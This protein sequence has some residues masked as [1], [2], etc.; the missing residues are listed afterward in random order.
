MR[1]KGIRKLES[2]VNKFLAPFGL[3]SVFGL[4]F[5]YLT[6]NEVVQ[7]PVFMT[8]RV[9]NIF[10]E[11]LKDTFN[12]DVP[13]MFIFSLLHEVG[14]HY[15]IDDFDDKDFEKDEKRKAKISENLEK[16]YK[17]YSR[18]YFALPIEYSANEWAVNYFIENEAEVLKKGKELQKAF[19]HF[20]KRNHLDN[21]GNR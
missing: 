11:W 5:A 19:Y 1:I 4:D 2:K 3:K 7:F 20:Y 9:D 16:D 10:A 13:N 12:F 18:K 6:E 15:T 21:N 14:H 8:E 17:K